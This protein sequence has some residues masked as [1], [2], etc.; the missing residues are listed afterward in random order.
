MH[1]NTEILKSFLEIYQLGSFT[2]AGQVLGLSQSALS[3]KMSR[4]EDQLRVTIFIR[5]TTGL[6]LTASGQKLLIYAK[7]QLQLEGDFLASFN[8]DNDI[9][10][11]VFRLASYS[12]IVRSV[13]IPSLASWLRKNNEVSLEFSS[14]EVVNLTGVLKTNRADAI[15]C[16]FYPHLPSVVEIEIGHEEYVVIEG[17]NYKHKNPVYLDHGPDDNATDLF[18]KSQGLMTNYRRG[19]MGDVYGILDGVSQGLGRAVMSKHLVHSNKKYKI[20]KSKKRY[21]RPVVLCFFE[22]SYYSPIHQKVVEQLKE[23]AKNYLM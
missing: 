2:K 12:S 16:D 15:I 18:F 10:R 6:E 1:L 19:F 4:L 13:L 20:I 8:Q 23:N 5:K 11:G 17:P 3:Q 7:Q 14:H 21:L 9:L 22:Q